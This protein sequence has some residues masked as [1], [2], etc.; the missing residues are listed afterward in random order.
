MI[1]GMAADLTAQRD[2]PLNNGLEEGYQLV[3]VSQLIEAKYGETPQP[4]KL[5][6]YDYFQ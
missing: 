1:V 2:F 6:G 5:Y 4:S 3:T